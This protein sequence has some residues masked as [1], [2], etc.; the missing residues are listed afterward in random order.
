MFQMEYP[1]HPL[2]YVSI[3]D[4]WCKKAHRFMSSED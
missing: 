2:T 1:I 4:V 3:V